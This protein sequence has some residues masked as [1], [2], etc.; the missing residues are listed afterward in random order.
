MR[1][2]AA[3]S[4]SVRRLARCIVWFQIAKRCWMMMMDWKVRTIEG[5]GGRTISF[6]VPFSW[7]L[8]VAEDP[9]SMKCE[10]IGENQIFPFI[11]S[12]L[13][14]ECRYP[15]SRTQGLDDRHLDVERSPTNGT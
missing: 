5:S 12:V 6:V 7:I 9:H 13:R 11:L 10:T 2:A 15:L 8:L 14:I 4:P 1:G 3:P